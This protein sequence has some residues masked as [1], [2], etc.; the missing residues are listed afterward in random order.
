MRRRKLLVVRGVP[1]IGRHGIIRRQ[2]PVQ[3]LERTLHFLADLPVVQAQ[4]APYQILLVR[5]EQVQG[6][7]PGTPFRAGIQLQ[8]DHAQLARAAHAVFCR[9]GRD[10]LV[11]Q[12]QCPLRQAVRFDPRNEVFGD[13][14]HLRVALL[15]LLPV[16]GVE[17]VDRIHVAKGRHAGQRR[18]AGVFDCLRA[19]C[20]PLLDLLVQLRNASPVQ[21]LD[22]DRFV[23]AVRAAQPDRLLAVRTRVV[24]AHDLTRAAQVV[25]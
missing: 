6:L 22:G 14:V 13:V 1:G 12:P 11:V 7:V 2:R 21:L 10:V 3:L 8:Q 23:S 15:E 5:R 25:D 17:R 24:P 20:G 16:H 4:H 19:H 9:V 18:A